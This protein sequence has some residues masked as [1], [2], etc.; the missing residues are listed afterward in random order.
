[1]SAFGPLWEQRPHMRAQPGVATGKP[2]WHNLQLA[3]WP[4]WWSGH[5]RGLL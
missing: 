4:A 5:W 2:V 3:F 1:M